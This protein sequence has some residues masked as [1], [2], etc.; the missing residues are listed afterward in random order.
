M[1]RIIEAIRGK[2]CKPCDHIGCIRREVE[3]KTE[4]IEYQE[5]NK[6]QRP[7]KFRIVTSK[8][9]D[10]IIINVA[11]S[12]ALI[13]TS[14]REYTLVSKGAIIKFLDKIKPYIL[15]RDINIAP[16][17]YHTYRA[18]RIAGKWIPNLSFGTVRATVYGGCGTGI[19][20]VNIVVTSSSEVLLV[21]AH[22]GLLYKIPKDIALHGYAF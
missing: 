10:D 14:N 19:T 9:L 12:W 21:D 20:R 3:Y 11:G 1:N 16:D 7:H 6:I 13:T 17:W 4:L 22:K 2:L 15:E 8:E 5:V 18:A